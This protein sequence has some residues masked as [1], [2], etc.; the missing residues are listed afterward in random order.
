LATEKQIAANQRN[1]QHS[2]GPRDTSRTSQNATKHGLL[3]AG[4]TELDRAIHANLVALLAKHF[5]PAGP[6]EVWLV[7]QIALHMARLQRAVELEQKCFA[8]E[9]PHE[10]PPPLSLYDVITGGKAALEQDGPGQTSLTTRDIGKFNDTVGRYETALENKLY[11]A[12]HELERLQRRRQGE[13]VPAPAAGDLNIHANTATVAG[14][15]TRQ[16]ELEEL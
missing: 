10:K 15:G 9:I 16:S 8:G 11:R 4:A 2:T 13:N 12:L 1:A 3:A 5:R 7:D 6:I 14:A